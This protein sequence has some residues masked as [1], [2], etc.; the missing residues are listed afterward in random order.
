[1]VTFWTYADEY[2]TTLNGF[3]PKS[4]LNHAVI[5]G[6]SILIPGLPT[7]CQP[8]VTGCRKSQPPEVDIEPGPLDLKV[9]TL[10]RCCK[11][12]L[13]SNCSRS[14]LYIPIPITYSPALIRFVPESARNHADFSRHATNARGGNR[15][16]TA[17]SKG[18]HYVRSL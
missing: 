7:Y 9:N 14:V 12:R 17:G 4:A 10:P 13:L 6:H 5:P 1:M 11:S 3:V 18:K 8:N 15:T 16:W 2:G